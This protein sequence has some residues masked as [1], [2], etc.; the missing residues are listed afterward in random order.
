MTCGNICITKCVFIRG[1]GRG[2]C[3]GGGG[4]GVWYVGESLDDCAQRVSDAVG[5]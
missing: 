4:G 5:P 2:V 3:G 1:D